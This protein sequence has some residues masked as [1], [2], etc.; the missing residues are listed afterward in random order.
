MDTLETYHQ[1]KDLAHTD[2]TKNTPQII[3]D[4]IGG[5]RGRMRQGH[6]VSRM[7][8]PNHTLMLYSFIMQ[9]V[10]LFWLFLY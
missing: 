9:S 4:I 7:P 5:H 3:I 6:L 2:R 8:H 10:S 1:Q